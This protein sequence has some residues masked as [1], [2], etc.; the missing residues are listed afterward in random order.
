VT[1]PITGPALRSYDTIIV[2]FSGGKDATACLLTLIEAGVPPDRI[3]LHHHAVDGQAEPF[4]D[5]PCT[6]AGRAPLRGVGGR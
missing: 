5:W 1:A 6:T 3:E 2:A 4:M